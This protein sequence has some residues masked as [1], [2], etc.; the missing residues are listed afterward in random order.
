VVSVLESVPVCSVVSLHTVQRSASKLGG[1]QVDEH[2]QSCA[3]GSAFSGQAGC[4]TQCATVGGVTG[5]GCQCSLRPHSAKFGSAVLCSAVQQWLA[6]AGT[7]SGAD[8][9]P[10]RAGWLFTGEPLFSSDPGLHDSYSSAGPLLPK[11]PWLTVLQRPCHHC[12]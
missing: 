12:T 5:A 6:C 9:V 11:Q 10:I 2:L 7:H 8:L 4:A 3:V 1:Q